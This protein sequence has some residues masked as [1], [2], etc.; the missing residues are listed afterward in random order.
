MGQEDEIIPD[1]ATHIF[2]HDSVEV[3]RAWEFH[4]H[5]NIVE[6]ICH[7][8]VEKIED[9]AFC[10]CRSLRRVI[11]PGVTILEERAFGL[12]EALTDVECGKLEIV[13]E[14]AFF[15]CKSLR[16]INLPSARIVEVL[17]FGR[18]EALTDVKF[19]SMLDRIE[20]D[21]FYDCTSL[22]QITIPFKAGMIT[23]DN[24]FMG[25]ENLNHANLVTGE[26]LR[27]TIA[28]LQLKKWRN[29]IYKEIDSIN[30][31]L[32]T[33][34]AGGGWN[35]EGEDNVG[36]KAVAIRDWIRSVLGKIIE[37]KAEHRRLLEEDIAPTLQRVLPQDIVMN[38][39]LPFLDVPS[40]SFG[41]ENHEE[42]GEED[43]DGD[44]E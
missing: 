38:N 3:V 27:E 10:C 1:G 21:A 24:T 32:P 39:V 40:H 2:V 13:G 25:C 41:L 33:A 6:V 9:W 43:S 23:H 26:L 7:G 8:N 15:E 34:D 16:S 18:C 5:H 11:M 31:T 36:E 19:G 22:A 35:D 37:Y 20:E 14:E 12:C 30:Q 44:E 42:G 4:Q 29:D 17:A 28:A